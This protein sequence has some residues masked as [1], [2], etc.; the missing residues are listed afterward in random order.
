MFTKPMDNAHGVLW[1]FGGKFGV[2]ELDLVNISIDII[3]GD[4]I[5][6]SVEGA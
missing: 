5:A 6:F 3:F 2:I 4:D 1:C